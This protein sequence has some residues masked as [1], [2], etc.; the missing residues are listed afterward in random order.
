MIELSYDPL[1]RFVDARPERVVSL[2]LSSNQPHVQAGGR[3]AQAASAAVVGLYKEDET[4]EVLVALHLAQG[5]NVVYAGGGLAPDQ[6]PAMIEEA[7]VFAE[8]MGFLLDD[9]GWSRLDARGRVELV[10]RTPQF[11]PPKA[12]A[13][14]GPQERVKPKDQVQA[15]A[16]LFAAFALLLV[17]QPFGC[18][19][20]MSA[21]QRA[22][23]AEIHYELGTNM[24][25]TGDPQ[26][27][28]RE[29][30][31]ASES[32]PE[33]AQAHA[34]LGFL[35]AF[36]FARPAE[37]EE[38]FRRA[39]D[40]QPDY[41][42]ALNNFGAFYLSRQRFA[43]AIPLFERALANPLYPE[44]FIA[45][46]NLGWALYKTGKTDK[47][48]ARLRAAVI[49]QPK[50]CKGWRE[51]GMI[52]SETGKLDDAL[53]S[54]GRYVAACP[55]APDSY[56]QRAKILARAGKSDEARS[57]LE[58]CAKAPPEKDTAAVTECSK[59]LHEMEP[60]QAP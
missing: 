25:N 38:E 53:E 35:Y 46:G 37:A 22:R 3:T 15:V 10:K 18:A 42:A 57:D 19:T 13:I 27:A 55:D 32:N 56:L 7:M 29:Y 24:L 11:H 58:R 17:I 48:I 12:P 49:V 4:C 39:I 41:S 21:E 2:H 1:R 14:E 28:L 43:E 33:L 36:S 9:S 52:Y 34:G 54:Y 47:G 44:R 59:V 51:L 31:Q 8:S 20:G 6:V 26:G 23:D 50:Y 60:K 30:L 40:I 16:R 45:E 5:D